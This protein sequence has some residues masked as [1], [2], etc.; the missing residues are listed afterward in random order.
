MAHQ[1]KIIQGPGLIQDIQPDNQATMVD[2]VYGGQD[3]YQ[4][5]DLQILL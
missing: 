4:K 2:M 5:D 1:I 3:M